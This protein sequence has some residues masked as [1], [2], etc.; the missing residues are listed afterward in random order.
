MKSQRILNV[1]V[2]IT[3]IVVLFL[4]V[5]DFGTPREI[6]VF[7]SNPFATDWSI[8]NF[9]INAI[10]QTLLSALLSFLLSICIIEIV[11]NRSREK[12]TKAKSQSRLEAIYSLLEMPITE[13]ARASRR[14]SNEIRGGKV[15]EITLPISKNALLEIFMPSLYIDRPYKETKLEFYIYSV[16]LLQETIKYILLNADLT[17]NPKEG[18]LFIKYMNEIHYD[19]SNMNVLISLK[20][21]FMKDKETFSSILDRPWG[22]IEPQNIAY[23][24]VRLNYLLEIHDTFFKSLL[25]EDNYNELFLK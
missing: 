5:W 2:I 22:E 16:N 17:N 14:I 4:I 23:P 15:R 12:E 19:L 8:D 10:I 13:Y 7:T 1:I 3:I 9:D 20:D 6:E 18:E 24:F 25:S 21:T 11:L